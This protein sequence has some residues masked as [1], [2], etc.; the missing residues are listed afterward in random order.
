MKRKKPYVREHE[1]YHM[2]REHMEYTICDDTCEERIHMYREQK[3]NDPYHPLTLL[4]AYCSLRGCSIHRIH[5]DDYRLY[6]CMELRSYGDHFD[7][8]L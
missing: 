4:L 1:I 3:E 2:C 6:G 5:L 7:Q 8:I